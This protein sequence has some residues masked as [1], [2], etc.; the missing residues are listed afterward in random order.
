MRTTL[1]LIL[2]LSASLGSLGS[3][4]G[5][6]GK[7]GSASEPAGAKLAV[8]S[9]E[10]ASAAP[11]SVPLVVHG[12]GF[13]AESRSVQVYLGETSANVLSIDSDTE[14]QIE[15]PAGA[16]GEPVDV[17]LVFEPGG[18]ITLPHAFTFMP[19]AEGAAP[20]PAATPAVSEVTPAP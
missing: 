8:T 14:L 19:G 12:S 6:G 9:I 17:K 2:V 7:G 1:G 5:C 11:A 13:L 16:P 4:A 20:A 18:E 3:L 10:P 15:V